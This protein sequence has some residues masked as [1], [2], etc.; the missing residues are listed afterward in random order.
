MIDLHRDLNQIG[1]VSENHRPKSSRIRELR[2]V[3]GPV[4]TL[5]VD[6][7]GLDTQAAQP[8]GDSNVH[9]LIGVDF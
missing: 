9:V 3:A 5:L 4:F 1:I 8:F 6:G 2:L 7:N